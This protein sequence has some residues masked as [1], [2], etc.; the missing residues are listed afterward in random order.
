MS[1]RQQYTNIKINRP[2]YSAEYY[3]YVIDYWYFARAQWIKGQHLLVLVRGITAVLTWNI[4]IIGIVIIITAVIQHLD[5]VNWVT[6]KV[7]VLQK[8]ML[9]RPSDTATSLSIT[10]CLSHV[11]VHHW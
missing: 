9:V 8:N 3:F 2:Q 6:G 5:K 4:I 7:S 11:A 10:S 1:L